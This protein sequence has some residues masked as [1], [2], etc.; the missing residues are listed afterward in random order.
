MSDRP[1]SGRD[2][3]GMPV[4]PVWASRAANSARVGVGRLHDRMVPPFN[5]V[6]DRLFAMID[7]KALHTAV[8]LRIPDRL[9]AGPM[10]ADQLAAA[11]QL[12]ADVDALDRVLRFLVS[13][14]FFRRDK[15][16]RYHNNANTEILREDHP[17]SW[18]DWAMFLASDWSWEIWN[19]L[20][21]RVRTGIPASELSFDEP[22]F[23]YVNETNPAAGAAFNGAMAAGSRIQAI[24]FGEAVDL[25]DARSVCDVGGG[26]GSV[27]AHLLR[28]HPHLDGVVFDLP[29][30]AD[31]ANRVLA[32]A[33][34]AD[35]G[36]FE[37]GDFFEAVPSGHD[38]YTMFA[39]VHDW[40]DD[41]CV[42]ILSNIRDAMPA[43]GRVLVTER[44]L[45]DSDRTDF[46]RYADLLMLM[47]GDGGRERTVSDY[48]ELGRRA[49]L[50]LEGR[51]PLPSL[52]EVFDFRR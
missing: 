20:P 7:A 43:H 8:Y 15:R 4:P 34:L 25:A 18:R 10:T 2:A 46:A 21:D 23:D 16:G 22:F 13:R 9:S 51:T 3:L 29:S 50:R 39:V 44:P 33:E 14:G 40:G 49:G 26:T 27:L 19:K 11:D 52:F 42:R 37:G 41:D 6:L 24:L 47:Y 36:A 17:Y 48:E 1:P 28:V 45:A 30:L 31:A 32:G 35:R 38:V 5:L 12:D